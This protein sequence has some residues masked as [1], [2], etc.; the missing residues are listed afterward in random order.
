[1]ERLRNFRR[2]IGYVLMFLAIQFACTLAAGI[3][4]QVYFQA[5]A[6]DGAAELYEAFAS[7]YSTVILLSSQVL[8]ILIIMALAKLRGMT[9][10]DLVQGGQNIGRRQVACLLLAGACGNILVSGA[11]DLLPLPQ[12]LMESYNQASQGLNTSLLWADLLSVA[13]FAPLVE[14][15]IFRGLVFSR[16]RKALPGWLAVVLQGLVFGFVHGQLVWIVYAT[17]FGLLLG[18]VR[19]RT[20]SLKASILL[21]LGFNLSSFFIGIVFYLAPQNFLGQLSVTLLGGIMLAGFLS[22]AFQG[23]EQEPD[24]Q[25]PPEW[26]N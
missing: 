3:G 20:G 21:H 12:Q 18:Y 16:L 11:M 5:V 6:P 2:A 9:L 10:W 15:M 24:E 13:V 26:E 19:L 4:A 23:L 22:I 17:L 25:D 14:E 1:M 7:D 8:T